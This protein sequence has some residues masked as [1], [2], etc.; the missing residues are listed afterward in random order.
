MVISAGIL[1]GAIFLAKVEIA[2]L[3]KKNMKKECLL[4]ILILTIATTLSIAQALQI[5]IPNP[6]SP[7]RQTFLPISTWLEL[8]T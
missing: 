5:T 6:L 4:F 7:I 1:I 2:N 8:G 3:L